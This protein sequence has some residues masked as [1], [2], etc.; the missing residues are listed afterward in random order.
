MRQSWLR[1]RRPG[2]YVN[3]AGMEAVGNY[4]HYLNDKQRIFI[5]RLLNERG[6]AANVEIVQLLNGNNSEENV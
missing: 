3:E 4:S 2:R 1:C 5:S 6:L